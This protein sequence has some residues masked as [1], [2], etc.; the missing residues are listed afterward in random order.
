MVHPA[1]ATTVISIPFTSIGCTAFMEPLA[2]TACTIEEFNSASAFANSAES[3]DISFPLSSDNLLKGP[4]AKNNAGFSG[5]D[6]SLTSNT[7]PFG[8]VDLAFPEIAQ[9]AKESAGAQSTYF[10]TDTF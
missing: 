2:S 8:S 10:F 4:A 5:A 6:G 3:L 9:V 1:L 7:V